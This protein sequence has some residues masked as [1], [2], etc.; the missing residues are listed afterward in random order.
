MVLIKVNVKLGHIVII[1]LLMIQHFVV[2]VITVDKGLKSKKNARLVLTS[3]MKEEQVRMIVIYVLLGFIVML[4][5][6]TRAVMISST[7]VQVMQIVNVLLGIN[8]L[9]DP[10]HHSEPH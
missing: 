2:E 4:K 7:Q 9:Q 8:V 1:N 6:L 3:L 10:Q 5:I